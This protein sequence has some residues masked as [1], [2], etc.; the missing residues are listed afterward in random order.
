M[1]YIVPKREEGYKITD[2]LAKTQFTLAD[3]GPPHTNMPQ[4]SVYFFL[5]EK[6]VLQPTG[7]KNEIRAPVIRRPMDVYRIYSIKSRPR[8][9][10][11]LD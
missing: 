4:F 8:I 9:N 6:S 5:T 11:A 2:N 3:W 7:R 10:A 1:T